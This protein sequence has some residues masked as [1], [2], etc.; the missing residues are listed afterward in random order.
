MLGAFRYGKIN[1]PLTHSAT[2]KST[3]LLMHSATEKSTSPQAWWTGFDYI[4]CFVPSPMI[5]WPHDY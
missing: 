5:E 1:E 3:S 2:E 4:H